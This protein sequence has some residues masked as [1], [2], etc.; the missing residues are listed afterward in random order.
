MFL[1]TLLHKIYNQRLASSKA[2]IESYRRLWEWSEVNANKQLV[3]GLVLN[4]IRHQLI[5]TSILVDHWPTRNPEVIK[6]TCALV[7][8]NY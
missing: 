5:T 2:E 1:A 7:T 3:S 8:E 4:M 6:K